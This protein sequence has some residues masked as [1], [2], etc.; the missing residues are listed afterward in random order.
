MVCNMHTRQ[1]KAKRSSKSYR[2]LVPPV[3]EEHE[4]SM[5][6]QQEVHN[7]QQM[8]RVPERV[9]AGEVSQREREAD[10]PPATAAAAGDLPPDLLRLPEGARGEGE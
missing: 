10:P 4:P 2:P 8:V 6:E 5:N 1:S 9:E 3:D 7:N